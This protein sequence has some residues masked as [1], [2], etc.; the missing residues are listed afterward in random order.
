MGEKEKE[1]LR[2]KKTK[3]RERN[4]AAL[5]IGATKSALKRKKIWCSSHREVLNQ[6][7]LKMSG[8]KKG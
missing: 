7:Y 3:K 6:S 1:P 4:E 5:L 8:E 2:M